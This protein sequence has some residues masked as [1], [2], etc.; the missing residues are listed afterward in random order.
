MSVHE[1]ADYASQLLATILSPPDAVAATEPDPQAPPGLQ[2]K[3]N[4][5]LGWLKWGGITTGVAGF[6]IV[7]IMMTVG[8]RNRS[9]MAADGA[10]GLPWVL[11]GLSII[12]IAGGLVVAILE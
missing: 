7:G 5:I 6:M 3:T 12:S 1:M 4:L 2:D 10:S 8:R 11:A 9:S